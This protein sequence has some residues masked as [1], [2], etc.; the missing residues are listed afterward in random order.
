[1]DSRLI[2]KYFQILEKYILIFTFFAPR[3]HPR[4]VTKVALRGVVPLQHVSVP[5]LELAHHPVVHVGGDHH[6][7]PGGV[8]QLRALGRDTPGQPGPGP[9]VTDH[10]GVVAWLELGHTGHCHTLVMTNS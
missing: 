1:M 6:P 5:T 7:V 4:P 9:V 8:R 2:Q 10:T 3:S